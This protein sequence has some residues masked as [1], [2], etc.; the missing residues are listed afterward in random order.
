M[1]PLAVPPPT[2]QVPPVLPPDA[3]PTTT[4]ALTIRTLGAERILRDNQAINGGGP[5]TRAV[6]FCLLAAGPQGLPI[7]TLRTRIWGDDDWSGEAL[8]TAIKRIRRDICGV[9]FE[10]GIYALQLPTN[11]DYD[12]EHFLTLLHRPTTS[13]RLQQAIDL[14]NGP[15][16][17]RLEQPWVIGLRNNLAERYINTQ[18]ELATML[19]AT[20]AAA[21]SQHYQAVLQIDPYHASAVVGLMRAYTAL[22]RRSYALDLYHNYTKRINENGLDPDRTVEQVYRQLLD[23]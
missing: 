18:V 14:Y 4:S 1:S 20:D 11:T 3:E 6:F 16:L 17:P 15:Y 13:E 21:A 9:R 12:V 23:E 2:P 19:L 10:G 8:K 22:G 7:E 5:L